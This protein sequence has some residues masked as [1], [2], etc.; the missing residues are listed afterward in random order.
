[1][2]ISFSV[3]HRRGLSGE[4]PKKSKKSPFFSFFDGRETCV[5][6]G[7]SEAETK[8][9]V[10]AVHTLFKTVSGENCLI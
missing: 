1:M 8:K 5:F 10:D 9:W 3:R 2:N 4:N 6:C 7:T